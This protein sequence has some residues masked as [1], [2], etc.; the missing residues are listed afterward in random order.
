MCWWKCCL[1][2]QFLFS[3]FYHMLVDAVCTSKP[4]VT[5]KLQIITNWP[6]YKKFAMATIAHDISNFKPIKRR[7]NS[8]LITRVEVRSTYISD[9]GCAMLSL[10][11]ACRVKNIHSLHSYRSH[12][13]SFYL[14][15]WICHVCFFLLSE[16]VMFIW[17]LW[18]KCVVVV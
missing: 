12:D 11:S 15:K 10:V 7:F 6:K 4:N 14:I 17:S 5:I 2:S 9:N 8:R 18:S 1:F 13:L 16:S 3:P